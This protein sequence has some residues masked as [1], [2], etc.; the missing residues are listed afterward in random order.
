MKSHVSMGTR[1]KMRGSGN[2]NVNIVWQVHSHIFLFRWP[3]GNALH[4]AFSKARP[5]SLRILSELINHAKV[6]PR[7]QPVILRESQAE[8]TSRMVNLGDG[9]KESAHD[10]EA[11][12]NSEDKYGIV[13]VFNAS[14]SGTL[15]SVD[16]IFPNLTLSHNLKHIKS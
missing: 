14:C 6:C 4:M 2:Q 15:F 13:P 12:Y 16:A 1:L 9:E 8:A 11:P 10:A 7:T 5:D 3:P